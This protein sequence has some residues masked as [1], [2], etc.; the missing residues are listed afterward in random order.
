MFGSSTILNKMA[1]L[2]RVRDV[3]GSILHKFPADTLTNDASEIWADLCIDLTP[4]FPGDY[5]CL[6]TEGTNVIGWLDYGDLLHDPNKEARV[7]DAMMKI[8]SRS[9]ISG[10]TSL[11]DAAHLF[12]M[13]ESYCYLVLDRNEIIGAFSYHDLISRPFQACLF[14]LLLSIEEQVT[15]ILQRSPM[16]VT[17][18]LESSACARL[19][20]K[21]KRQVGDKNPVLLASRMIEIASFTEK[22]NML[23]GCTEAS[24]RFPALLE[25]VI[26]KRHVYV[27]KA[28]QG[29]IEELAE[30]TKRVDEL[31]NLRNALAH[32]SGQNRLLQLLPRDR[33]HDIMS[34]IQRLETELRAFVDSEERLTR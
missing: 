16:L 18:K 4:E 21:A 34:W 15:S 17:G 27:A 2:V 33:L 12:S 13:G 25:T 10:D 30:P 6:V 8:D 22:A 1:N 24:V 11:L 3:C 7:T 9:L 14:S 5:V 28:D 26:R 32:P 29:R 19:R 31:Q 23:C 20:G